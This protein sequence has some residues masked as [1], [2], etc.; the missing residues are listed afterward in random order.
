MKSVTDG[1][2]PGRGHCS[3]GDVYVTERVEYPKLCLIQMYVK[4]E[5][6]DRG[7]EKEIRDLTLDCLLSAL[8]MRLRMVAGAMHERER[9]MAQVPLRVKLL[10]SFTL[11]VRLAYVC[12]ISPKPKFP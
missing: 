5:I 7:K 2:R 6:D 1:G 10:A 11:T 3:V 8:W 12:V 4:C 9:P